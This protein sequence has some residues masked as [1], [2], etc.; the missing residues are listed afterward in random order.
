M[1]YNYSINKNIIKMLE[2]QIL[3]ALKNVCDPDT[4]VNFIETGALDIVECSD[5]LVR[6]RIKIQQP[7]FHA[8]KSIN[9]L[10]IAE[11]RKLS[12]E[13][14]FE[15][16]ITELPQ[17]PIQREILPNVKNII[18]VASGKGGVGKSS[19]AANIAAAI[20]KTGAKVGIL[21][22]DVYGPSQ[23]T[24]FGLEN[25]KL[26]AIQDANGN[27][28][29]KPVK[30]YGIEIASM[31]FIIEKEDAVIVRGPM[32][33][34][35]FSM[36]FEQIHWGNLDFLVFDLPPGTGD[37]QLT[38]TQ[39]IPLNG[40][41]IVTTPQDISVVDVRRSVSMFRK[42]NVDILGIIENMSYFVPDDMPDKKYRI[43]GEGGGQR[44]AEETETDFLG[45]VPLTMQMREANDG[46]MP[47]VIKFEDSITS[48]S[49]IDITNKILSKVRKNNF[50]K[51]L[52]PEMTISI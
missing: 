26:D 28:L 48:Q 16:L 32:L 18:A 13:T 45:Q 30:K 42:V 21:D 14:H 3:E 43:F 37:I 39:K 34:G 51:S 47:V 29:A 5:D 7:I 10:C 35:Y 22:G 50:E 49:I 36:L 1:I 15:I 40:A 46:G 8:V 27:V 25:S 52:T 20:A 23:P 44:I 33:A 12:A 31:G 6:V 17:A 11:L 41:V 19:I 38:L 24:M 4:G 9:D 2:N